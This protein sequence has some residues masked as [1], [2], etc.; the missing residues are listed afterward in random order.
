MRI[1]FRAYGF[2]FRDW[3]VLVDEDFIIGRGF[4]MYLE[5]QGT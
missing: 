3:W 2:G 5:G 1:G 4:G